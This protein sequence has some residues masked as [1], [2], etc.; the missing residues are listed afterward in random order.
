M[1]YKPLIINFHQFLITIFKDFFFFIGNFSLFK[2]T[3]KILNQTFNIHCSWYKIKSSG[4]T[5]LC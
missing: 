4:V 2:M 3:R 1:S 5:N